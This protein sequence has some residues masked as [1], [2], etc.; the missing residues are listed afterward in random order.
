MKLYI[1]EGTSGSWD[2]HCWFIVGIYDEHE[3]AQKVL[4]ELLDKINKIN[5]KYS[6]EYVDNYRND[7]LNSE[8]ELEE[9]EVFSEFEKWYFS[10]VKNFNL[11][12]FKIYETE[13]NDLDK[14]FKENQYVD[15]CD[16]SSKE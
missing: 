11:K 15:I 12:D 8:E 1:I 13:L 5:S 14:Y 4:D 9:V 10:G 16:S 2:D 7:L 6:Q 3:K